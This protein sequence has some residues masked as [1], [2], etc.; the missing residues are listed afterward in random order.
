MSRRAVTE[1]SFGDLA[2]PRSRAP[3]E[4]AATSG[5]VVR[6]SLQRLVVT[7]VGAI[8]SARAICELRASGRRRVGIQGAVPECAARRHDG[9][10]TVGYAVLHRIGV[11]CG[12]ARGSPRT[13]GHVLVGARAYVVPPAAPK[14]RREEDQ[15]EQNRC[16]SSQ[17]S[18]SSPTVGHSSRGDGARRAPPS[19]S[20]QANDLTLSCEESTDRRE[21]GLRQLQRHV[22]PSL[23]KDH[24]NVAPVAATM[25]NAFV[26]LANR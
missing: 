22:R 23:S 25:M 15:K 8:A 11:A 26:L 5:S 16:E 24:S 13:L 19:H 17:G 14:A 20:R 12:A 4:S 6:S 18:A 10:D 21:G 7:R 9:H 2:G 3:R 1:A